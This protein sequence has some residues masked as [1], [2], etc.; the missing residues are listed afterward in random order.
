M[1]RTLRKYSVV[2]S[3]NI[4]LGQAGVA[5]LKYPNTYTPPSGLEVVAIQFAEDSL[6]DSADATTAD[7]D[8]PT[9]VQGGPGTNSSAIDQTTMPQGLTIFGRWKTVALDSG[10]AFLYLG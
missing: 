6:L 4:N 2:E 8:W 9:D 10:S 7:S 3:G 1:A 5:F